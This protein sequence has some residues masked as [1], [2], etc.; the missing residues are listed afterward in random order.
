MVKSN[1]CIR[2]WKP[3]SIIMLTIYKTIGKIGKI[4][5]SMGHMPFY[6]NYGCHPWKGEPNNHPGS[7]NNVTN[8]LKLLDH[9]CKDA[10]TSANIAAEAAK[11]FAQSASIPALSDFVDNLPQRNVRSWPSF[12][13]LE[14]DE[15]LLTC[16]SSS[17]P[18]P[19]H[20]SWEYLKIF[21]K[22]D[23]FKSFFLTLAND[24]IL[25]GIWP[26][27]F[28]ASMTV[29]IPK[30][31][32]DDYSKPKSY[33]PI[34]LLECPCKL[35]SKMIANR[36]QSDISI[37]NI[38]HPLQFG[39]R[40][41]HSTLDA[42]MYITDYITKACNAGLYT[43]TLALDA[44]QFFPSLNKGLI[45]SILLKEGFHP[46]ITHLFDSYYDKRSTKY[47]WNN[48]FS[49]DYDVSNG[50]PQGNPLSPIISVIYMS[51]ML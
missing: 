4:H 11:Q 33:R 21:L 28:K 14:L 42:G 20:F 41:H 30:P 1:V 24:I 29:I 19:S 15:A 32:K 22:D 7:N 9:A 25:S 2:K 17:A 16:S 26:D 12:S 39:G 27:A 46:L 45:V 6:L 40:R 43:T 3:S 5:S 44:A 36:L 50:V 38:A 48:H 49:K 8:F 31:K 34:A 35:V 18:G 47:L 37:F 23:T 51:A 10:S 13:V